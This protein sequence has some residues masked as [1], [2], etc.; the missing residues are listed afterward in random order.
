MAKRK[1]NVSQA[2]REFVAKN[3]DVGPTDTA[4][5]LTARLGRKVSPVYVSNIKAA[6][7]K[8]KSKKNRRGRG[9]RPGNWSSNHA[10]K[11][12]DL[13]SLAVLKDLIAKVGG[14][15]AKKI[16]EILE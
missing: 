7:G 6:I 2:I 11:L 4:K 16:I 13:A 1:I 15:T 10:T 5:T 12:I 9:H 8:G 3:P 14:N